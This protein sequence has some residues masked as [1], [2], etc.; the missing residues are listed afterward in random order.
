LKTVDAPARRSVR[1]EPARR[2]WFFGRVA[3]AAG[4]VRA[5]MPE[6]SLHV[7]F[8]ANTA[9]PRKNAFGG[10]DCTQIGV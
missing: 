6:G 5:T 4:S 2:F 9:S 1:L 8:F 3:A 10:F 7:P